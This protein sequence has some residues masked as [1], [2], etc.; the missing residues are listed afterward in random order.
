MNKNF[1]LFLTSFISIAQEYELK[2]TVVDLENNKPLES[3]NVLIDT[4]KGGGITD[5]KGVFKIKLP[6]RDYK[7]SLEYLGYANEELFISLNKN[8][9][10]VVKMEVFEEKLSEIIVRAKNLNQNVETPQ[11]GVINITSE[12]LVKIPSA[13]GEFDV[14]K[15]VT[16]MAGVNNAGDVSNGIS[17]R[18]GSLDQN[19]MLYES[20][21]VFNPTLLFG[22]LSVFTPDIISKLDM[23]QANIPSKY[24][25]RISS[26]MDIKVKNPYSEKLELNGG[27]GLLSSRLKITTPILK[28]KLLMTTA[29]R[30]GFTDFLFPMFVKRLK[31]TKANF[32]DGTMKLLYIINDNNQFSYNYFISKDF[33]Q[34]DLISNI[35]KINSEF[36]QYDFE[37]SNHTFKWLHNFKN[38]TTLKSLYVNSTYLP[39]NLFP[40]F[41]S[42]NVIVFKSKVNYSSFQSEYTDSRGEKINYSLGIQTKKYNISPGS[43]SPGKGNSVSSVDLEKEKSLDF[44]SYFNLNWNPSKKLSFSLGLRHTLFNFL[45]PYTVAEYND[46]GE[47]TNFISYKN[48]ESIVSYQNFE[49]RIGSRVQLSENSSLKFSYAKINQYIQNIYNT[50]TPLPSS[51]WKTS[52]I[53]IKPQVSDTF[54]F[55]LFRNF[56]SAGIEFSL[57]GYYR[58]IQNTLTYKPGA[59]FFLSEFV[60]KDVIQGDG[61]AYGIEFS[62]KKPVGKLNG[63]LNYTWARS[64]LKTN[65]EIIKDRINNNDWYASD[66][67]R[68]HTF[69]ATLTYESDLHNELSFNFTAQSGRPYTI[70]NT[71]FEISNIDVPIYLERN[72]SRFPTYQRLDFSWKISYSRD[73]KNRFK[74]DWIFTVYNVLGRNNP[75]NIYYTKRDG[76]SN[77]GLIFGSSPLASYTLSI[78]DTPIISLTYNFRFK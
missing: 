29:I 22:L 52:D 43:L 73:P 44:S 48:N 50:V 16:L 77:D 12:Q 53:Y 21:P 18:G 14:L 4:S 1:F 51:R 11:M 78:I 27:I 10:I 23:Y 8:I 76:T 61:R 47:Q 42:N 25:G 24:G 69:N 39:K 32:Y 37:T 3:V 72:N 63:F 66:F 5:S 7:L 26:V 54:G 55:G 41:N 58:D 13:F 56:N 9:S 74:K 19:L 20:A 17:V 71:V 75:F 68:P 36:N 64:L 33:Y 28:D 70:A 45:G 6:S 40:E 49:P 46:E 57:E 30:G 31:N 60:E 67:D 65:E 15:S 62:L 38:N 35:E 34:L 59:D 2:L